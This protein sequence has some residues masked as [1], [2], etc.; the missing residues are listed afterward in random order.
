MYSSGVFLYIYN[1]IKRRGDWLT[2]KLKTHETIISLRDQN[3][4]RK[5]KTRR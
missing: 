3:Q 1:V 4:V 5:E 2:L